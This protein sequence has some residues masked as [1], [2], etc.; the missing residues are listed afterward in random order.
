MRQTT[1]TLQRSKVAQRT[2]IPMQIENMAYQIAADL[3]GQS[4]YDSY[5]IYT[6]G[7][8][9]LDVRRSDLLIDEHDTDPLTGNATQYR[10]FGNPGQYF[11]VYARIPAEKLIGT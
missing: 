6:T 9:I 4:P 8:G 5:W 11:S 7:G 10:V 3:G 1:M 2:G